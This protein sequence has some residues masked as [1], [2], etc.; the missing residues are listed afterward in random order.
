[1]RFEQIR[2]I[3]EVRLS[4]WDGVPVAYDNVTAGTAVQQAQDDGSPW[5]RLT[6][7]HGDSETASIGKTPN[8]RRT[9][10]VM[11]QVFTAERQGTR[12]AMEIAD[13]LADHLQYHQDDAFVLRAASVNRVGVSDDWYQINVAVPFSAG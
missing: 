3:I 12:E 9:G 11:C 7:L 2:A 10:T 13:S 5:V 1:M 4:E 6:I 8:V